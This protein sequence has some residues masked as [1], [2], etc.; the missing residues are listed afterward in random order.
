MKLV[1]DGGDGR[2]GERDGM[3]AKWADDR[4]VGKKN[5][6]GLVCKAGVRGEARLA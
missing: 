6:A 3:E 5:S 2:E 1:F 4:R